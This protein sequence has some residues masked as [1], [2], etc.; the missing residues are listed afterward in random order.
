MSQELVSIIIPCFNALPYLKETIDSV[1][2]QTYPNI[3]VIVVDDGS[4]DGSYEFYK[5]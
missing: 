2:N 1:F 5:K 3:E 4:T